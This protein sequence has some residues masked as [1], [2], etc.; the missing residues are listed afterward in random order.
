MV[1]T[2]SN[3]F[4][5]DEVTDTDS[6]LKGKEIFGA[7]SSCVSSTRTVGDANKDGQVGPCMNDVKSLTHLFVMVCGNT[8]SV[9]EDLNVITV[10]QFIKTACQKIG[11][12]AYDFYAVYGGKPLKDDKLMSCY[13][14]YK[15]ST[16]SL[17]QRLRAGSPR[18]MFFKCY[19]F[20][21]M[22]ESRKGGLFHVVY[23]SQHA[24]NKFTQIGQVTYL[25][26][27]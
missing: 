7:K 11:V 13:P 27:Y 23:L 1:F 4:R 8:V 19:T 10:K 15:D 24:T 2:I 22:I 9:Q 21:E 18:V 25:S 5:E 20:D 14:I 6:K 17:R 3:I 12:H 26:D 16:V